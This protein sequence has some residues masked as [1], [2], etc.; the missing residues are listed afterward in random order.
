MPGENEKLNK[1]LK[2]LKM[3]EQN[4]DLAVL[5]ELTEITDAVEGLKDSLSNIKPQITVDGVSPEINVEAPKAIVQFPEG[6]ELLKGDRGKEGPKGDKGN[7]GEVGP[8]GD[9]G[10]EGKEGPKGDKGEVGDAAGNLFTDLKDT[11]DT[12][13]GKK[14]HLLIVDRSEKG[15]KFVPAPTGYGSGSS[16]GGTGTGGGATTFIGLTDT[17]ATY[18]GVWEIPFTN[19]SND[20]LLFDNA[21]TFKNTTKALTVDSLNIYTNLDGGQTNSVWILNGNTNHVA[22]GSKMLVIGDEDTGS[23][24]TDAINTVIL[25]PGSAK[26]I[27][28][29]QDNTVVGADAAP[30]YQGERGTFLGGASDGANADDQVAIGY[31]ATATAG[32]MFITGSSS[33]PVITMVLGGAGDA[34]AAPKS[35]I[36]RTN[37][38]SGTNT[39]SG[40]VQIHGQRSTGNIDGGSIKFSLGEAGASGSTLNTLKEVFEMGSDGAMFFNLDP[41][42]TSAGNTSELRFSELATNGSNY[43]GFKAKDA[44]TTSTI[45]TLPQQDAEGVLKSNGSGLLAFAGQD[46]AFTVAV[47]DETTAITT[48]TAKTTFRMP[49]AMTLTEVRSSLTGAGSTSGT[50]AVDINESGSTI[51]ST[52]LTI[53]NTEKTSTTA[54]TPAVI[55]DSA[56]ADD[57]EIT[58]DINAVTGGADETGLKVTFI[59]TRT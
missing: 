4:K 10:P 41:Y 51:L 47:S 18:Q 27:T 26:A 23:A 24:V 37:N 25:G 44:I 49:F 32:G 42:G 12:Y 14:G 40:T 38:A 53:D 31:G 7:Q 19:P 30:N 46:E 36:W 5:N 58:I 35:V 48:G 34:P 22:A 33:S 8:K 50:T 52:K 28:N 3:F 21:F 6:L 16:G 55:S 2:K 9:Q 54:A 17:P 45:W 20:G 43:V 57:A 56:L 15:L 1:R 11:P 13:K 29:E 59:G 39:A